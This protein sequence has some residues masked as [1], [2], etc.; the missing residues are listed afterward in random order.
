MRIK[1]IVKVRKCEGKDVKVT[2]G[3]RMRMEVQVWVTVKV[4]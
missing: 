1:A 2:M 4:I 3:V